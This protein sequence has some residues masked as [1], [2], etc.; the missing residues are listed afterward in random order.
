MHG[1]INLLDSSMKTHVVANRMYVWRKWVGN[2]SG[3]CEWHTKTPYHLM[4]WELMLH[5]WIGVWG[6]RHE[7]PQHPTTTT[8]CPLSSVLDVQWCNVPLMMIQWVACSSWISCFFFSLVTSLSFLLH[9]PQHQSYFL[10]LRKQNILTS[11]DQSSESDG[12]IREGAKEKSPADWDKMR[13]WFVFVCLTK[14]HRIRNVF[15]GKRKEETQYKVLESF[16]WLTK[17]VWPDPKSKQWSRGEVQFHCLQLTPHTSHLPLISILRPKVLLQSSADSWRLERM[18]KR[19]AKW[20][21]DW[22][23]A[24]E[25]SF[26]S[27]LCFLFSHS[28]H[29]GRQELRQRRMKVKIVA[30]DSHWLKPLTYTQG[31]AA[32][33]F[34]V[35]R[36]FVE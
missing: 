28:T 22:W 11:R 6:W 27:V 14:N 12:I 13:E 33:A 29:D 25:W 35:R 3:F 2:E 26:C 17:S 1:Q 7:G 15:T 30:T 4:Q 9:A 20:Y 10:C 24:V 21:V 23:P 32:A 34:T 8:Y 31:A 19:L 5:W 18:M 16:H 36:L